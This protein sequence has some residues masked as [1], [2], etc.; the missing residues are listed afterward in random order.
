MKTTL[1]YDHFIALGGA[2]KVSLQLA[3]S[4]PECT[5][6]TAYAD[7]QLFDEPL[8][9]GQLKHFAHRYFEHL[10][11]TLSLFLFYLL[12]YRVI[13]KQVNLLAT[14]VFSPLVLWRHRHVAN[15]VV[16]FHTFPS[17]TQLS[18]GQL[19]KQHGLLGTVVFRAFVPIYTWFLKR[20]V[21]QANHVFANSNSVQQRFERIGIKTKVLYP[22]VDLHGLAHN[23]S[24]G[25]FLSTARLETN[26]R[27]ELIAEAFAQLKE[28]E[29]H[30]VGGGTLEQSL[31]ERY[32]HC[33]NIKFLGWQHPEQLKVMYNDC[34]ALVYLPDNE[35]FGIA[36]VE[37][38]AAGKPVIG[39]SQGGLLET[40]DDK[41]LGSLLDCP[42]DIEVFKQTIVDYAVS[43][44]TQTDV[45]FRQQ[46]VKRFDFSQF[47]GQLKQYIT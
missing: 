12:R 22:G 45:H 40:I 11:P 4:L 1:L 43:T 32:K 15:S 24:K 20:S 47:I 39:V 21:S 2:E 3:Q 30:I 33:N 6:E 37:A 13:D 5:I 26:K 17:F 18:F 44:D 46:S 38:M 23:D 14:G 7:E 27:V 42:I 8:S 41:R 16:Y 29:L 19:R 31:Q 10:F 34:R 9:S 28:H 36:P 25:Y 35:Y